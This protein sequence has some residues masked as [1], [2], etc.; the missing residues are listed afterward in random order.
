M[1]YKR[2]E[3]HSLVINYKET[4]DRVLLD[5]IAEATQKIIYK[6]GILFIN[7]IFKE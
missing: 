2:E 1:N 7:L 5:K 3:I 4:K 6:F